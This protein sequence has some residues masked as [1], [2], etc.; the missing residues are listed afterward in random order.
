MTLDFDA[1]PEEATEERAAIDEV[2]TDGP[3]SV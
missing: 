2:A 1:W 3:F